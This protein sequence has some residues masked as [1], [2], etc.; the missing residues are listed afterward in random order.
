M[1]RD[2]IVPL[3]EERKKT[4][5]EWYDGIQECHDKLIALLTKN[6][7]DTNK[8]LLDDCTAEQFSWISEVFEDVAEISQNYQFIDALNVLA[9]K[10]PEETKKYNIKAFIESAK[11]LIEVK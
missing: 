7:E 8:F 9:G 3:L 5:D 11:S 4:N 6:I 2:E 1:I 10:Y